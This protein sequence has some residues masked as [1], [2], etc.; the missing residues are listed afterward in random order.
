MHR[1][2][3]PVSRASSAGAR[4]A[5]RQGQDRLEVVGDGPL[6]LAL[7]SDDVGAKVAQAVRSTQKKLK[8]SEVTG[9][10]GLWV[11]T[12]HA[13]ALDGRLHFSIKRGLAGERLPPGP[14]RA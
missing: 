9:I 8:V 12:L 14:G 2:G 5:T 11:G 4:T 13:T 6:P 3:R 10:N 1:P 7:P